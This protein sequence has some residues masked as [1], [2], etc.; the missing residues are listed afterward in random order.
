MYEIVKRNIKYKWNSNN[1]FENDTDSDDFEDEIF[2]YAK[3]NIAYITLF[4]HEAFAEKILI[5]EKISSISFMSDV[6]GL[7]GLFMG[8]SFV[9]AV[10]VLYHGIT[11]NKVATYFFVCI[12]QLPIQILMCGK[13]IL[14]QIFFSTLNLRSS[15]IKKR[16][17][18]LQN[19]KY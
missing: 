14:L 17:K 15:S 8:F 13:K 18:N 6:G 9:S 7:L 10:E 1:A 3:D 16:N 11:V 19:F 4:I 5:S 2:N 12:Y